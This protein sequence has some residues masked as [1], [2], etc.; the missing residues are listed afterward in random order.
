MHATTQFRPMLAS[1]Q[2]AT[3]PARALDLA[4]QACDGPELAEIGA[5]EIF[6]K[7]PFAADL[8]RPGRHLAQQ[9]I[10]GER[11]QFSATI[12]RNH[13][14][15]ICDHRTA[16][17]SAADRGCDGNLTAAILVV[18]PSKMAVSETDERA[19]AFWMESR[20]VAST[21]P[22]VTREM[23]CDAEV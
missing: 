6:K 15:P 5:A 9:L 8:Q 17:R 4:G 20:R 11:A 3:L 12:L 22:G 13:G 7:S 21:G 1:H 19:G 16:E 18:D 2:A 23:Q 14:T 10:D